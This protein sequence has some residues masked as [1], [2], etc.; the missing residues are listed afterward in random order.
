MFWKRKVVVVEDFDQK[1]R[2]K[3]Y[4]LTI[5]RKKNKKCQYL[6][7]RKITKKKTKVV[8]W[9]ENRRFEK[10]SD[11]QILLSCLLGTLKS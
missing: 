7:K 5:K 4:T 1:K 3:E 10:Q 11:I 6:H 8:S 9:K 2:K